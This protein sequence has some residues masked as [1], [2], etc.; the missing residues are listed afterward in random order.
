MRRAAAPFLGRRLVDD[1]D[2]CC[3]WLG[4]ATIWHSR[5]IALE[6][7]TLD[8]EA[9]RLAQEQATEFGVVMIVVRDDLSEDA[10]GIE[11]CAEL[12]R[13]TLYPAL[14]SGGAE[15]QFFGGHRAWTYF[16]AWNCVRG[17]RGLL[18]PDKG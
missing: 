2:T 11:C 3:C 17:G 12:Y 15:S 7:R 18:P 5:R 9:K 6:H 1:H 10:G 16:Q 8:I 14:R 13:D 4:A